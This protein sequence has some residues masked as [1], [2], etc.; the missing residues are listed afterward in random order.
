M[1][2]RAHEDE[3]DSDTDSY[4]ERLMISLPSVRASYGHTG[5]TRSPWPSESDVG[6]ST[7]LQRLIADS[8]LAN[9]AGMMNSESALW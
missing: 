2:N 8:A 9:S 6:V 1:H 4:L 7:Q 5:E 3:G